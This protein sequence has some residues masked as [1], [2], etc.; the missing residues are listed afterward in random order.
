M[1]TELV[2]NANNQ[3]SSGDI[4]NVSSTV[5]LTD[6]EIL[7]AV[8]FINE[9]IPRIRRN[10]KIVNQW[11]TVIVASIVVL[12]LT[13]GGLVISN[14]YSQIQTYNEANDRT[15]DTLN[16]MNERLIDTQNSVNNLK[17][18]QSQTPS[19]TQTN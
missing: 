1:T 9:V 11:S 17:I 18:N 15:A 16:R 7:Q 10:E 13:V 5:R 14:I 3:T 19:N 8:K 4:N 2:S 12:I 6:D